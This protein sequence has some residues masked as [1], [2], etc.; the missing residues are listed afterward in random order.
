MQAQGGV[1]ADF[2]LHHDSLLYKGRLAIPSTS[3]MVD[4][5]LLEYHTTAIG[6][7]K[8]E[9]KTYLCLAKDWYCEGMQKMVTQFVKSCLVCQQQKA[10]HQHPAGLFQTL[11]IP[12]QVWDDITMDF[13][14]ALPKSGEYDTVLV[15]VDRFTKFAYFIGLKHPFN[16]TTIAVVFV[17]E[18]VRLHGFPSS[19]V[20]NRDKIFMITFWSELFRLQG[21]VLNRNMATNGWAKRDCKSSPRNLPSFFYQWTTMTMG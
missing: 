2:S 10:S 11:L 18:V 14:E 16:A 5:L 7:R 1:I 20:S 21:T 15:V 9:Y 6:G 13:I 3:A 17:K 19:I 8:G 12:T 4:K